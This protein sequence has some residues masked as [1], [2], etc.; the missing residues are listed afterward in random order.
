MNYE[1]AP[2]KMPH[3]IIH[4][5]SFILFLLARLELAGHS[6]EPVFIALEAIPRRG[7]G[8]HDVS[9]GGPMRRCFVTIIQ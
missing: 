7:L 2:D 5:S 1:K 6:E 9:L 4:P 3:F 8:E